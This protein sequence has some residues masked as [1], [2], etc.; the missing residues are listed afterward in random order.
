MKT[1]LIVFFVSLSVSLL[2]F[3]NIEAQ[4]IAIG[5]VTAEV[6]ESASA[7]S[8]AITGFDLNNSGNISSSNVLGNDIL[9]Y[10]NL[11]LGE[12]RI[13]SGKGM[14]C[15]IVMKP[16]SLSDSKG[17]GFTIEAAAVSSGSSLMQLAD[18]NQT[19]HLKG[20]THLSQQQAGGLYQGS[21]TMVFAYN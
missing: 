19:L 4:T 11:N 21:Y 15:N 9:E 6:V 7:A 16:A 5:H 10:D 18:G 14:A 20:R 3:M 13:N 1:L 17:N 8:M 12:I 2:T